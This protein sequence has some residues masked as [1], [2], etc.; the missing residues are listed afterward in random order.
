MYQFDKTLRQNQKRKES[1]FHLARDIF[2]ISFDLW[3]KAGGWTESYIPYYFH[4]DDEIIANASVNLMKLTIE[5]TIYTGIQIGTVMTRE[6]H[7]GK[8]LSE[9]LLRRIMEDYEESAD[10][11]YLMANEKAIPLYKRVGF[12]IQ[13]TVRF[14]LPAGEYANITDKVHPISMTLDEL[15]EIKKNSVPVTDR[16]WGGEDKHILPFYYVHGFQDNI[17]KTSEGIIVLAELDEDT[18][19]LYDVLS[20]EKTSLYKVLKEVVPQEARR[21]EI[22]FMPSEELPGLYQKP[23]P[24][25]GFM[26]HKSSKVQFPENLGYPT[27]ITA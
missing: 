22:H 25:N 13:D 4:E 26:L 14:F 24:E 20:S 7:R 21:V 10:F 6:T 15:M 19:H 18:F 8:G 16:F 12:E 27:I 17:L 2:G 1:F 23:F 5:G 9:K 3:E 11:I